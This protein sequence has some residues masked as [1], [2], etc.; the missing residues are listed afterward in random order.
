VLDELP[1]GSD[2]RT[3]DQWPEW[4]D[5]IDELADLGDRSRALLAGQTLAHLDLRDDNLIID[6]DGTAWVC[7]W[8]F[9]A[10][11]PPWVDAVCPA[12][13]MYGDGHDVDALLAETALIG[14]ADGEPSTA[15]SPCSPRTS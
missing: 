8:N 5:H 11:G 12:I 13:S 14:P 9:P 4:A 3:M 2:W 6:A 15:C 10:V 7:D 1:G